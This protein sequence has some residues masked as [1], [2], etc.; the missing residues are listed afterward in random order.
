MIKYDR[1]RIYRDDLNRAIFEIDGSKTYYMSSSYNKFIIINADYFD[2]QWKKTE[3]DIQKVLANIEDKRN[4][5]KYK[6][7]EIG[8]QSGRDNPVPIVNVQIM[9]EDGINIIPTLENGLTRT[10]YL[11]ANNVKYL[12]F[13]IDSNESLTDTEFYFLIKNSDIK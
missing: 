10:N 1:L 3:F 4:D 6:R 7:A 9:M 11:L 13:G 8:F 2:K 5:I 12:V